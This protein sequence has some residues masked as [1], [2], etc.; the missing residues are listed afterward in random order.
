MDETK[1]T[2]SNGKE[3]V[4]KEVKY[5][6]LVAKAGGN[7]EESAKF[8]LQA[9]SGLTDIEYDELGMKDGL[10]LQ[11]AINQVNGLDES[12]LQTAPQK[13]SS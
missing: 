10:M 2:I 9:S 7:K 13:P 4:I 3:Y 6:D 1:V 12:F 11:K 5:K 8:L